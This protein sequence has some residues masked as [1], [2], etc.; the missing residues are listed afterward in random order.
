MN[1]LLTVLAFI[2]LGAAVALVFVLSLTLTTKIMSLLISRII[3]LRQ[4]RQH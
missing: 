4:L 3:L 2:A 1:L